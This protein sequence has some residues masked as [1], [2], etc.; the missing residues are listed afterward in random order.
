MG[1]KE[2]IELEQESETFESDQK[3]SDD[4]ELDETKSDEIETEE[5]ESEE[6]EPDTE[7]VDD[8]S[9]VNTPGDEMSE[10]GTED[11][12]DEEEAGEGASDAEESGEVLSGEEEPGEEASDEEASKEEESGETVSEDDE[13]EDYEESDEEIVL[14]T[15]DEFEDR[16]E[17]AEKAE[18]ITDSSEE[19][20]ENERLIEAEKAWEKSKKR[21]KIRNIILSVLFVI[22]AVYCA[23]A[24][25]FQS[26]FL[27]F[28]KINGNDFSVKTVGQVEDYLKQQ[29]ADYTLTLLESDGD[30]EL[31]KGSE[32]NLRYVP[33]DDLKKLMKSQNE[34][35]WIVSLW[36]RPD[37]ETPVGVEYDKGKFSRKIKA[38]KCM[39]D[40]Q[41]PSI[42]AHPEFKDTQFEVVEEQVGTEIDVE[43]FSDAV[44][45]AIEEFNPELD[46]LAEGCYILPKYTKDSP[47]VIEA[48]KQMN[49]YLGANIT[50]DFNP[51][52]EVVDASQI[53]Q[54]VVV[55]DE[56]QVTFN[57]EL[58]RAYVSS[59]AEKYDTYGKPRTV[60]T[61]YGNSVEVQGGSFG[62]QIDQEAEYAA[63]TANIQ[64]AETVTREPNY[65]RRG[66]SHEG[67][68]FGNTYVEIDLTRQHLFFFQ[69]GQ[70]TLQSDVVTGNPNLGN[71]TPQGVYS[72]AYKQQDTT[73]RGPKKEDGTYEWESPVKYWMPFN[74]G[75]G[76]HDAPWRSSFGGTIYNG[77]GSHGCVNLP[78]AFAAQLY[79]LVSA[80][81]PVV[82]HY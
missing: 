69:N 65:I 77:N 59:L 28:T 36:E 23:V 12:K 15:E 43:V 56:M 46:M 76:L 79:P 4:I 2:K 17:D 33:G 31:I 13:P 45:K 61:G 60:V 71:G 44:R 35:M 67:N 73:L 70:C 5:T 62:W 37:I 80:G 38:L 42:A 72:I 81:M 34:W 32:I 22:V 21:K 58:V 3:V 6:K 75:I 63:L 16:I 25:F 1:D 64:N 9:E 14:I 47:E 82:C 68:D 18:D 57:Q 55:D 51:N 41:I 74:G 7:P 30:K 50:L 11:V 78:P 10:D 40:E 20:G 49:S 52:T 54:W 66:V 26:H 8:A 39:T 48:T 29:V 27:P 53:A 19:S 24:V